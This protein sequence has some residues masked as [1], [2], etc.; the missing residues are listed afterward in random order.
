MSDL[1]GGIVD[2]FGGLGNLGMQNANLQY[3]KDLQ[4]QIFAR[5]DNAIQR[6]SDDMEKAGFSKT[7]A[8]GS[9]A[10]AGAI[11][12]TSAPQMDFNK[13]TQK[14]SRAPEQILNLKAQRENIAQTKAN[15]AY[16]DMQK[17]KAKKEIE[18]LRDDHN[19]KKVKLMLFETFQD[20]A[21]EAGATANRIAK[22]KEN[23]TSLDNQIKE[24]QIT[25]QELD[26][27]VRELEKN[28]ITQTLEL[29]EKELLAKQLALDIGK[30]NLQ[31]AQRHGIPTTT[32]PT[33][34]QKYSNWLDAMGGNAPSGATFGSMPGMD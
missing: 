22:L 25:R 1:F 4:K 12:N 8:A 18:I 17:D 29:G 6:R 21:L 32:S 20:Q 7:L 10:G 33:N 2:L 24:N 14:L 34:I 16:T 5:E 11:V 19:M 9:P 26:Y 3:Q 28:R 13:A 15:T 23:Q 30:H 31:Y 27:V